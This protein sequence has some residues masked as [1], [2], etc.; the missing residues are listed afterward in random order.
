MYY[1]RISQAKTLAPVVLISCM[2]F[3]WCISILPHYPNRKLY[4]VIT[5]RV[6]LVLVYSMG[7]I[8]KIIMLNFSDHVVTDHI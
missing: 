2:A 1:T 8:I 5:A 3:M 4:N 7:E 6:W